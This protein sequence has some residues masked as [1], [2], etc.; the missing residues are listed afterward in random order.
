MSHQRLPSTTRKTTSIVAALLGALLIPGGLAG[1]APADGAFGLVSAQD[2]PGGIAIDVDAAGRVVAL[3][4][5]GI[6]SPQVAIYDG[7]GNVVSG[8]GS[9]GSGAGQFEALDLAVDAA[10]NIW[11]ADTGNDRILQFS[12]SGALLGQF[13]SSGSGD[14]QFR[15]PLAIA[16]DSVDQVYVVD[17][18]NDRVQ[19]FTP[20][21]TL[22]G[23]WGT[24]GAAAGQF[25]HPAGIDV[26]PSG[27]VYVADLGNGRIQRFG[28]DGTFESSFAPFSVPPGTSLD[29]GR[30]PI[31]ISDDGSVN[32]LNAGLYFSSR[33][34]VQRYSP[35]GESQGGFGCFIGSGLA[36]EGT[37]VLVGAPEDIGTIHDL[38][39]SPPRIERYGD[40]GGPLPCKPLEAT[41]A[42][43]QSPARLKAT[44]GCPERACRLVVSG[45]VTV[46]R[47]RTNSPKAPRRFRLRRI[48]LS[49]DADQ[50]K[51][52]RLKS[53]N[54]RRLIRLEKIS[55]GR[56]HRSR[57]QVDVTAAADEANE[58]AHRSL[59]IKLK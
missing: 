17:Q 3:S 28:S 23:T 29:G 4:P 51:V 34:W 18:G 59:T 57:V 10:G 42:K 45:S 43:R 37:E 38:G 55:E 47:R 50:V 7:A 32:V 25:A 24:T 30:M 35:D 5:H 22:L 46:A 19:K 11:I 52:V 8:F 49:L 39:G 33:H 6:S 21:G 41:A 36:T 54:P 16:V 27:D 9:Y 31:A 56:A 58:E 48:E 15:S 14:G 12:P 13:G 44:V 1:P 2:G 53:A 40:P 20:G 26:G